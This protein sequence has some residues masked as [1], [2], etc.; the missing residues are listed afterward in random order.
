MMTYD[1][2]LYEDIVPPINDG[3]TFREMF[4]M[5]LEL[6]LMSRGSD[7]FTIYCALTARIL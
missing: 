1:F 5:I 7:Q 2:P 6:T 4:W 3:S